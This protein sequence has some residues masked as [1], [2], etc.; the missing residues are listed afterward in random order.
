MYKGSQLANKT[1]RRFIW[2]HYLPYE[3]G[4]ALT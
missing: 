4:T 1:S 3:L 2:Q